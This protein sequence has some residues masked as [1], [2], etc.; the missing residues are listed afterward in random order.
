[1]SKSIVSGALAVVLAAGAMMT[2][3]AWAADAKNTVSKAAAKPLKAGSD[4]MGAKNYAECVAKAKEGA[5]ADG[6]TAFDTFVANQ[7]MGFCYAKLGNSAEAAAAYDAQLNSGFLPA[8]QAASMTKTLAGVYY[9]QKDYAKSVELGTRAIKAGAADAD[10][11]TL[12]GQSLYLQNK[13]AE[14]AKFMADYVGDQEKRG[15]QPKEQ[16]LVLM[17]GSYEKAGNATGAADALEKLVMYYPKKE[18]WKNLMYSLR[19]MPGMNDRHTLQ[20]YRL[21]LANQTMEEASDF[22][23][24]AELAVAGGNPAEAQKVLEAG[25]AANAFTVQR[26]KD[27]ATRMLESV[28][29]SAATDLANL[30]K[31]E[32][33][34]KSAKTGDVQAALGNAYLGFGKNQEAA[35]AIGAALAKGG[36]KNAADAQLTQGVAYVRAG[37]KAEALKAFKAV[38]SDDMIYTRIAKLWSLHVQ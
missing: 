18:Y 10:T 21:M 36:L 35:D 19:R 1:M 6:H 5:A 34:A 22:S 29:K 11:Y 32:G 37:N 13:Y 4:A 27:R 17:R 7:L 16:S 23:E 30:P 26:D 38:K 25:F 20:V 2:S 28:K 33:E 31:L 3:P 12:V 14:T 15:Q 9:G 24:M 8:D